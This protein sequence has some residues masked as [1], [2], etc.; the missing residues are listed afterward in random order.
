[1]TR[2]PES[3][4][5]KINGA[6]VSGTT[7]TLNVTAG[8]AG[9]A[10]LFLYDVNPIDGNKSYT[11]VWNTSCSPADEPGAGLRALRV[12]RRRRHD[13]AVGAGH[14]GRASRPRGRS[15]SRPGTS[16]LS[17]SGATAAQL[18][19]GASLLVSFVNAA[20]EV[21]AF[22]VPIKATS[23]GGTVGGTVPATL[24]LSPR[25]A[26]ELRRLHPGSAEDVLRV[27]AG[28]RDLHRG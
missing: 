15:R 27:H 4:G 17:L 7:V 23:T 14:D 21:Q 2:R 26:G 10:R 22:D 24:S 28:H 6:T 20:N 13:A 19:S 18:A 12:Q 5:L 16:T 9:T 3:R 11:R 1:M 8:A 25:R